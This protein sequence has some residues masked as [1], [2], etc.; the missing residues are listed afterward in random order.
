MDP[1]PDIEPRS[2]DPIDEVVATH[3]APLLRYALRLIRDEESAQD[4][5]QETFVRYL[6]SP[7]EQ[8]HPRQIS[9][10]L[11]RVTHNLCLDLIR[12]E[13]RMIESTEKIDPPPS[14]PLPSARVIEADTQRQ[15][16]E[17]LERLTENQRVAI[18]LKVQE[19]KTY[20]EISE[21]TGLSISNIGY[22]I[23]RGLKIMA[24]LIRQEEFI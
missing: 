24:E 19:G 17:L 22:L 6:R 20:R 12:K 18:V 10:W 8:T 13:R 7:P 11:Y 1:A 4:I 21:I 9:S 2:A 15:L 3:Q 23:H 16:N 5:V 14:G